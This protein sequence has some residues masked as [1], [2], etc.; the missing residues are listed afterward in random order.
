MHYN[1]RRL[2]PSTILTTA[3]L[4]VTAALAP[5]AASA[6]IDA[7]PATA[8][9]NATAGMRYI[10]TD[11]RNN[12]RVTLAGTTFTVDDIVP[13]QAGAGC[14][15]VTGDATKVTCTAF[16]TT[17]K[18]FKRFFVDPRNGNDTVV[19]QTST[20]NT[21]GAPMLAI[22]QQGIDVLVGDDKVDDDLRGSTG[23]DIL[24]GGGGIDELDG[25][26][27]EDELDGGG[28]NDTLRGG[29]DRDELD[30]GLNDDNLD[31]GT[32]PDV[33]DGGPHDARR[34]SV[35][36]SSR[37]D[38]VQ[39]D[40]A[41]TDA[42]QGGVGEG[43]T[44][45]GVENVRGG[46]SDDTL[47]GNADNNVLEGNAGNDLLDGSEGQDRLLGGFGRDVLSPS[48]NADGVADI[49]DC[50]NLGS[51]GGDGDNG[52]LAFRFP[53]DGDFA[54]DCEQVLDV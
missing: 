18:L 12:V 31:G 26:S 33:F 13:I 42:T 51:F 44:I 15:P 34:D 6:Q 16:K 43:D 5:A 52:D 29:S 38:T 24:L 20:A 11:V 27:G 47:R 7:E 10:G 54:N 30:G 14:Q 48:F 45:L 3:A 46:S 50:D 37:L 39:V 36:Y 9:S 40:L 17:P 32:G 35:D 19:N 1:T 53:A 4:T 41:R 21:V 28:G 49:M 23:D 22:A 8:T 25:G 2:L